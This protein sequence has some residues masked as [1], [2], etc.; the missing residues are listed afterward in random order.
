MKITSKSADQ[1]ISI[2][3][4]L[5]RNLK[6]GDI[7]CL[8]GDLGSGK[9]VLTKGIASAMGIRKENVVSPTFVLLNQ[10]L[11]PKLPLFH[12]DLY[13]LDSVKDIAD[14]GY[15]EYFYGKGISVIEWADRLKCLLPDEYLKIELSVRGHESR[16]LKFTAFGARHKELLR[17]INEDLRY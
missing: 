13:R 9:T 4:T 3:K 15:E 6:A 5:A 10:Y 1:T 12:F 17:K 16:L 11:T 2:G 14:L 7:I 8:F